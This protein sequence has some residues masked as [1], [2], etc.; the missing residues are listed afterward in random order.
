M[1]VCD[2]PL[3]DK[4]CGAVD[5]ATNPAGTVTDGLGAWIAKS[6][7][8]LASSAADL[9]AK[10]VN[11]TTAI[12]LNAGWF[13]DNYEL[14]LPIGLALTVGIFCIQLM[15]AA[16]RRDE[17]ALA[18]AA[19][20]T[21]TGVLFSFSAIA[22]TTVAITVVDALSDG[23][24][25][26]ANTSIDDAIRRVIKVDQMGAMYG[27]GWGVPALV[28]LGCAIGAFL[29]W[30]VMVARK[31]GVLIMVA[32]AVFAGAGGGW[33][34]AK[35]WRRGW[36]E[37]TGTLIVSKL[38]MTVVFLIGVSAMGKTDASDGMAALSDAMAGIVVMVLVLLCPYA[39][40]KFVHW[41][42]DGGGHDDMHRTGVAG[43]AVAAGAAKTAGSLAL[44]AGTG[45]PA[46]Q[47]PNQ[48]PGAGT[49]GVASGINPSG[50]NLSKEGIDAGP[51]KQQTRFRYGEDPDASGDKGR[52][53]IQRPGIPPLITRPGEDEPE[54]S[55]SAA[56]GVAG[57]S[58]HLTAASAPGGDMTSMPPADPGPSASG[59]PAS[60]SGPSATGSATPTNWVYPTQPPSGS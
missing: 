48:V 9:A 36:I 47:G 20:G 26:A 10:A 27:L 57:G 38:L 28:A 13:R 18:K 33:E 34:V 32:L 22:F 6:A 12:D 16:W 59:T 60:A 17:R 43:M 5:F 21:M 8:E 45:A 50:G 41:A 44:R 58:G 24:F 37:A 23:L 39:T 25:K 4:V 54:G 3:M 15:T 55:E 51:P 49:D 14:L 2:F 53:L 31:V 29:Y 35:R 42:S 56:Q 11:K 40:Y 30:G 7:G 19:F 52:A 46:P 1:G